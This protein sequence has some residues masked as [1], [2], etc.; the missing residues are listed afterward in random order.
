MA[1]ETWGGWGVGQDSKENNLNCSS[2]YGL[3]QLL[4]GMLQ[5]VCL[6]PSIVAQ[7]WWSYKIVEW[8]NIKYTQVLEDLGI[9]L[10]CFKCEEEGSFWQM[11][12]CSN[13]WLELIL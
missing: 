5:F 9:G 6:L 2:F 3:L 11:R 12:D 8:R 13:G 1:E 10:L 7:Q 4:V